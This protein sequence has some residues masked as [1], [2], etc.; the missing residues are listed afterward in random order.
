MTR[1]AGWTARWAAAD[2][3]RSAE[4]P[5]PIRVR[6]DGKARGIR[7]GKGGKKRGMRAGTALETRKIEQTFH[8]VARHGNVERAR[9]TCRYGF[10]PAAW[11][12]SLSLL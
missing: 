8:G 7:I 3:S 1:G 5:L 6:N 2:A 4:R 12:L 9:Y 11:C 10:D